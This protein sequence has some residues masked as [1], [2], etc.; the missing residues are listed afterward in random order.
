MIGTESVSWASALRTRSQIASSGRGTPARTRR[1]RSGWPC[2]AGAAG[3]GRALG[4]RPA[5]DQGRVEQAGQVEHVALV[6][7]DRV[8]TGDPALLA[9]A[10]HGVDDEADQLD[11]AG[12][13]DQDVLGKQPSVGDPVAVRDRDRLGHLLDH[14]G[15]PARGQQA[16][17]EQPVEGDPGPPLVDDVDDAVL[18]GGVEHPQQVAVADQGGGAGGGEHRGG[19]RVGVGEHVHGDVAGE[20]LV[21]GPPEAGTLGVVEQVLELEPSRQD[22]PRSERCVA[23]GPP[24]LPLEHDLVG[25]AAPAAHAYGGRC[26]AQRRRRE[27]TRPSIPVTS[28]IRSSRA[29]TR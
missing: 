9:S 1:G 29:S 20:D 14:P 26:P 10:E 23:H 16:L 2:S 22:G 21:G 25:V 7:A 13:G 4:A 12:L 18:L 24:S 19:A 17:G 28:P 3:S 8:A 15:R 11:R 5:A 27:V 6:G